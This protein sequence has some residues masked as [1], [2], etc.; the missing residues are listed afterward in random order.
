MKK[1][2]GIFLIAC[3]IILG[4]TCTGLL[5]TEG[6]VYLFIF[7]LIALPVF[8]AG[9]W[10]RIGHALTKQSLLNFTVVF[11]QVALLIPSIFL[12]FEEYAKLKNETFAREGYLWFQPTSS[13]TVGLIGTLLLIVLVLSIIPKVLFGLTHGGKQLTGFILGMFVLTATFLYITWNDYQAIH[14]TEGII[15]STWWGNNR[16]WI[17]HRWKV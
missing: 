1:G 6:I 5:F 8:M 15:V 17:G 7:T 13:S 14:E 2:L 11:V 12:V 16:L 4:I 9:Q 10:L 3:G